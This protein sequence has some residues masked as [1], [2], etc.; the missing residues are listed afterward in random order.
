MK[1]KEEEEVAAD[2]TAQVSKEESGAED[3]DEEESASK[4]KTEVAIN[5]TIIISVTLQSK[6]RICLKKTI[7][8]I[9]YVTKFK[10]Y[11]VTMI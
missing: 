1:K 9:S 11:F 7:D 6:I 4:D 3:A 2:T 10:S 5:L 8:S